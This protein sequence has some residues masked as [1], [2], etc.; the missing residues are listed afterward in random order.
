MRNFPDVPKS[1]FDGYTKTIYDDG[2]TRLEIQK[3]KG[4]MVE[5]SKLILLIAK[6][7]F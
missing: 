5:Y 4:S 1:D 7:L 6:R 2:D 3:F